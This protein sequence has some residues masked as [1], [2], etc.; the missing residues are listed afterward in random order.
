MPLDSSPCHTA[1]EESLQSLLQ[2]IPILLVLRTGGLLFSKTQNAEVSSQLHKHTVGHTSKMYHTECNVHS[3]VTVLHGKSTEW[4][5][6]K[7]L[8]TEQ[9]ITSYNQCGCGRNIETLFNR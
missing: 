2:V 9:E 6:V 8:K 4:Y 5:S 1:V 3:D 7:K